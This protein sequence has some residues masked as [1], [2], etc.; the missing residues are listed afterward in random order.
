M[1]RLRDRFNKFWDRYRTVSVWYRIDMDRNLTYINSCRIDM[2]TIQDSYKLMSGGYRIF[3]G[4]TLNC[5]GSIYD[6]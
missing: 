1:F 3:I 2:G 5:I 4:S 6:R